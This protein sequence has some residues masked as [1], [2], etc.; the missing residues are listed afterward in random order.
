MTDFK[1]KE[2]AKAAGAALKKKREELGMFAWKVGE[3]FSR[4]WRT[5]FRWEEGKGLTPFY[6]KE[7]MTYLL[8][9][10]RLKQMNAQRQKTEGSKKAP[11]KKCK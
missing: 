3:H 6:A 2:A 8:R 1:T 5:I 11:S 7:Y 4:G 10:E 9:V